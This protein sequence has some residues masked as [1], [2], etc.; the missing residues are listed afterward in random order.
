ME[1]NKLNENPRKS[2]ADQMDEE[3]EANAALRAS[4]ANE[5]E[6]SHVSQVEEESEEKPDVEANL[7]NETIHAKQLE[8]DEAARSDGSGSFH[9]A[10]SFLSGK[11]IYTTAPS[12]HPK[13]NHRSCTLRLVPKKPPSRTSWEPLPEEDS[14]GFGRRTDH[15][16]VSSPTKY[17]F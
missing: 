16:P 8:E 5:L 6:V 1:G 4:A 10:S 12:S 7:S 14:P 11:S 2:W 3:D 17:F 13:M 9:T 15:F